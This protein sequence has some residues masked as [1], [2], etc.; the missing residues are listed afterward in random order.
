MEEG[1]RG[2][3]FPTR[4][5]TRRGFINRVS[6]AGGGGGGPRGR[7]INNKFRFKKTQRDD[8]EAVYVWVGER[9]WSR[10]AAASASVSAN[11]NPNVL[12]V[13]CD[14]EGTKALKTH[15]LSDRAAPK[16]H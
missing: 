7:R 8:G 13:I 4:R 1:E 2:P 9:N 3:C 10:R 6:R 11:L 16:T 5:E 12:K 15:S 14:A